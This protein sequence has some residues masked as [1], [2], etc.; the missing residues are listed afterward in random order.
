MTEK[1]YKREDRERPEGE[2]QPNAAAARGSSTSSHTHAH[3]HTHTN[4]GVLW[5][6]EGMLI[7]GSYVSPSDRAR[8]SM[9][10]VFTPEPNGNNQFG[11]SGAM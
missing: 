9:V 11:A 5:H 6:L 3:T 10:S 8:L 4:T 7:R 1:R 2:T